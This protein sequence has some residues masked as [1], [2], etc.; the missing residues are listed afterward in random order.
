MSSSSALATVTATMHYLLTNELG[1]NVTTKPPSTARNGLTGAQ[2]NLFLYGV[3]YNS[4][5]SNAPL[6]GSARNGEHAYPPMPL[7][8]KYLIT[9]YGDND[10][11]ISAQVLM[12]QAMSFFHDRPLLSRGDIEGISPDSD[13]QRQIERIR[14]THDALSLDDMSKLWTSF[15]SAEYRLST[16]YEVSAVLIESTRTGRAPLPVLKRGEEDRGGHIIAAPSASLSGFRFS[17]QKPSAELGDSIVL[18]GEHLTADNTT[19]RLQHPLLH[20]PIE[21]Q[22]LPNPTETEMTVQLPSVTDDVEAG[23]KWPAGFYAVSLMQQRPGIPQWSS[24]TL[25][26][27]LSPRIETIDPAS[28]PA[29]DVE[30]TI[31]CL[32][33]ILDS[34]QVVLL[35]SDR[36]VPADAIVTPVDPEARTELTFTIQNAA[37]RETPYVVRLRVD[38]VD[39]IPVDFSGATPQFTDNQKVSI[40]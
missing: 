38:G 8:L 30:L 27:P 21:L 11:D 19:V 32:P 26:L 29:G 33:Q 2:L 25:F 34:Q 37:S 31:E 6:P 40:T 3:H 7:V 18:L 22:P 5:F 1:A 12:G 17:N 23:S 15:Q 10:D 35:F 9:A 28:A 13:L 36:I 20:E 16:G 24:N 39:S 4:A 14:I